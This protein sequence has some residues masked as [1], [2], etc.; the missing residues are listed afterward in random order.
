MRTSHDA[1]YGMSQDMLL[2]H[3]DAV[4]QWFMQGRLGS[5]SFV[6]RTACHKMTVA[7]VGSPINH[8]VWRAAKLPMTGLAVGG[9]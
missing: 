9:Q 8:L 3:R 6:N 5:S 2:Q 4:V 1:L 7:A